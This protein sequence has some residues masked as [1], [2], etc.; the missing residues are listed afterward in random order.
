MLAD[1][2]AAIISTQNAYVCT[3]YTTQRLIV[4][5]MQFIWLKAMNDNQSFREI[6][7]HHVCQNVL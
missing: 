4:L 2:T 7:M 6:E 1:V 3:L 5:R